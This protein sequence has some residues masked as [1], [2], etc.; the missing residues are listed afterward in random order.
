MVCCI[1]VVFCQDSSYGRTVLCESWFEDGG[2]FDRVSGRKINDNHYLLDST[3]LIDHRDLFDSPLWRDSLG[4]SSEVSFVAG[5]ERYDANSGLT[6]INYQQYVCGHLVDGGEIIPGLIDCFV[7]SIHGNVVAVTD[8]DCELLAAVDS[9]VIVNSLR[10]ILFE[11]D[12]DS[13]EGEAVNVTS[14]DVV[15]AS[16]NY[17]MTPAGCTK[18]VIPGARV[19]AGQGM[20]FFSPSGDLI[21]SS[22]QELLKPAGTA[23]GTYDV[24]GV[25]EGHQLC[26]SVEGQLSSS[27]TR[28][29]VRDIGRALNAACPDKIG[30]CPPPDMDN[31]TDAALNSLPLVNFGNTATLDRVHLD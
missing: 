27:S 17:D 29:M 20:Y 30:G 31:W 25:S 26:T 23:F 1:S 10:S 9:I 6:F 21:Y 4:I 3:F 16:T 11:E 5:V 18:V 14:F 8:D 22:D 15:L 13:L 19:R 12:I 28:V 24:T 7:A 2:F